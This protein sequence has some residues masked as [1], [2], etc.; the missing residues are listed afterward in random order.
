MVVVKKQDHDVWAAI[1]G[2]LTLLTV[3]STS[4]GFGAIV[5]EGWDDRQHE[6]SVPRISPSL[7]VDQEHAAVRYESKSATGA[8]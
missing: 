4:L 1:L 7:R 6:Q 5:T 3:I 2:L 8:Y